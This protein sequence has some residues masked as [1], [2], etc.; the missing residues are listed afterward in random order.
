M[1]RGMK[2]SQ[3]NTLPRAS[4]KEIS[5]FRNTFTLND[6]GLERGI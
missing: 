3:I 2:I 5:V 6:L 4:L 1:A